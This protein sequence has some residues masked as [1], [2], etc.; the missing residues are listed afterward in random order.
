MLLFIERGT[1]ADYVNSFGSSGSTTN[2]PK[3]S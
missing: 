2:D 3:C 1:P